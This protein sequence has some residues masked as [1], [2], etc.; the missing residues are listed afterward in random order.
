MSQ[1]MP[2]C[3]GWTMP[4]LSLHPPQLQNED[5]QLFLKESEKLFDKRGTPMLG[6]MTT[7]NLT[8]EEQSCD[9]GYPLMMMMSCRMNH[10]HLLV[11]KML[12]NRSNHLT[13][14]IKKARFISDKTYCFKSQCY[15]RNFGLEWA[16]FLFG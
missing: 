7:T 9:D 5:S 13:K 15:S 3:D 11:P 4:L 12:F 8:D 6:F 14:Y 2:A 10:M 1:G 16:K